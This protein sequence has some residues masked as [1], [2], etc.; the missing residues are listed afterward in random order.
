SWLDLLGG[1]TRGVNTSLDDNNHS[2]SFLAGF[3]VNLDGGKLALNG[4]SSIGPET[5][6]NNRDLRYLS[7]IYLTWKIT[8]KWTS[9]TE[10]NFA[11]DDAANADGYGGAQYLT[12]AINDNFTA[13]IRAE[14]WR[15]DKGFYVASFADPHDPMRALDGQ[16]AIDP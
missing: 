6:G 12:Y 10:L 13:K 9:I 4:A 11:R 7:D 1:M 15:D 2:V 5:P 3:G 16:P 8:D 14:V